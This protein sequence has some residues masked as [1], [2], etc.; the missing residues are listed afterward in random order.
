[1]LQQRQSLPL[2]SRVQSFII[3][4]KAE[5]HNAANNQAYHQ[6]REQHPAPSLLPPDHHTRQRK[7]ERLKKDKSTTT[8]MSRKPRWTRA[9]KSWFSIPRP[10]PTLDTSVDDG[11][12]SESEL[13]L[14]SPSPDPRQRRYRS[15]SQSSA[16][17]MSS[18]VSSKSQPGRT[19]F[20]YYR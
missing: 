16:S 17:S 15:R 13:P 8:R 19:V 9:L 10:Q 18:T 2:S 7:E 4:F 1:M 11:T 12:D 6:A 14:L 20:L 5:M 3:R